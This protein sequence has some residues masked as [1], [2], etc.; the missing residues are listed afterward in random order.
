[1]RNCSRGDVTSGSFLIPDW[2][3]HSLVIVAVFL[4]VPT[5]RCNAVEPLG[6]EF[7]RDVRPILSDHCFEC[8]GPD[9]EQRQAELRLDTKDGLFRKTD[10][11][12]N[13][14]VGKSEQSEIFRRISSTD[15][16]ER[17]PP[18][19]TGR[20][21][22]AEQIAA[23]KNWIDSGAEWQQHWS[24]VTPIRP[25]APQVSNLDWVKNPIDGFV[26]ARLDQEGHKPSA[27][28]DQRTLLRRV[29]FDLTGL[30]PTPEEVRA[31][32]ADDSPQAYERVVDRLL[33]SPRFAERMTVRWLDAA[34]YADTNGYQSDGPRDMWRWRDWVL[35]AFH[36]NMPFDQFT[37]EQL[38]GDLLP[39][40][41]LDQKIATGFNRNHRGNAEG[42]IV[43]EEY[44]VEY[45]VDRVDTTFTVWQGLTMGCARCH[46]HKFDPLSQKEYYQIFSS[47]NNIPENGRALKEGN[48]PPW[49]LAPTPEQQAEVK[50]LATKRVEDSRQYHRL[51]K[52]IDAGLKAWQQPDSTARSDAQLSFWDMTDGLLFSSTLDSLPE[53]QADGKPAAKDGNAEK[54]DED[55]SRKQAVHGNVQLAAGRRGKAARFDGSGFIETA[56]EAR[57]GY[58]DSFS[59]GAHVNMPKHVAG[60]VLSKMELVDRGSG[61]N[62]HITDDGK[63]QVNLVKRWLDDSLRV[64][65]VDAIPTGKWVHIFATYDGTR[66]SDAIRI[67][68]DGQQVEHKANLD[69]INQ[70][71]ASDDPVRIGAGN[72]NFQ[73]L[74]DEVRIYDRVVSEQQLQPIAEHRTIG[75][76]LD[77]SPVDQGRLAQAKLRY[78]F[79]HVAAS[80]E[81][82]KA[83]ADLE[84]SHAKFE[85]FVRTLP[86]VMVMQ[87]ME[88]PRETHVLLRGQ[89]DRPGE[90]A[91]FGTPAALPPLPDAAPA[92]RLGLARWLVSRENPLTARVTVNRFWR[93]IFGTGIVK[94]TED[95]GVQGE[96]PSH[97]QLLDWLAVEFM[98]S[99]WDVKRLIKTI[100]MSN[101]Y[102]QE[103]GRQKGESG[104]RNVD[105][106]NRLLARGPRGRLSAEMIRDQALMVG[107]LLTEKTGGPSVR[108]YQ[109]DGLLK[110]IASDTDYPQD[111]GP[112]L[113]R[114]S[115]YT[116]WKRTVAPPMMTNFDA[117]GREACEVRQ[118]RTNTPLQALNLLNDVTFVEASRAL[119]QNTLAAPG[120][121]QQRL[122]L[123]F[124]RVLSRQPTARE[125]TILLAGLTHHRE[126][127]TKNKGA[128]NELIQTG[129]WPV[130]ETFPP[131]ELAAWTTICSTILNLDEAVTKE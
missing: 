74:I 56:D 99:G 90:R 100:V 111:H 18:L 102:R 94:T 8:H 47:F 62:L 115:L 15:P 81:I 22:T 112:D 105:P 65:S 119:A 86:T 72:S 71:F 95:F 77:E 84:N 101:T 2:I 127:F 117:T 32:L 41:T 10:D 58:F 64:E 34:R 108:P 121:D 98:E 7:N 114:R 9:A 35:E 63:V 68:V 55:V 23:I 30:P 123:A 103:S 75:E 13:V 26:L 116:Y 59:F 48:S 17:M 29:S 33:K 16:D 37:I 79:T 50:Q 46:S 43:P 5:A 27:A 28:A 130:A 73:G 91:T 110:E 44:Q 104:R 92:N 67:Y 118:S 60:T 52:A 3:E 19:E 57:F 6:V 53:K 126:R 11:H 85:E 96:R 12:Q 88:T 4:V 93:D 61:Y 80:K 97:P 21:L 69:G 87:E 36:K 78:Y 125:C 89:Y 131:T 1:M 83:V 82:R 51:A 107:G 40:A 113:Y 49:I 128:A 76:L 124:E 120:N 42:G 24:F 14:V 70:S 20:K 122:K 129:E 109:P 38:A 45:V 25:E 106:D 66:V 54:N 39:D 31:F